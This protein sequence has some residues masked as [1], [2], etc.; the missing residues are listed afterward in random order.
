MAN[1]QKMK[2]YTVM[3]MSNELLTLSISARSLEEA[4][5]KAQDLKEEDFMEILGECMDGEFHIAGV[6][7]S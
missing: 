7:E 6:Y 3:A 5:Q 4:F 2:D 1:K